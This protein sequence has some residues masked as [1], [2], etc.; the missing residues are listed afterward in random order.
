MLPVRTLLVV[1]SLRELP[2]ASTTSLALYARNELVSVHTI[3]LF[4]PK[5]VGG[6]RCG[7]ELL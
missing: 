5:R 4:S 6:S 2:N 3:K 7:L 1:A